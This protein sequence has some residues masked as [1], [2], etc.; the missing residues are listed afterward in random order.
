MANKLNNSDFN[1]NCFD[2]LGVADSVPELRPVEAYS[3]TRHA[4][5]VAVSKYNKFEFL[6]TF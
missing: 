5:L 2:N 4:E 3:R 6:D 1:L